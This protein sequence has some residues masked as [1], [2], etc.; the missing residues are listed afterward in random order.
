MANRVFNENQNYRGT[1]VMYL[2]LMTEVPILILLTV[3][4]INSDKDVTENLVGLTIASIAIIG[5]FLLIMNIQLQTRIDDQGIHYKFFPF[6][7]K[8]RNIPR[9]KIK[10]I[11]VIHYSPITDYGGWG[12]KGNKTTK[13]YSIVGDEGLLIDTGDSKKIMLGT[14]KGPELRVFIID[15]RED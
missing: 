5:T 14:Q 4:L 9:E 1:W 2:L 6:I 3:V 15:W 7:N 13:A 11:D 12:L 10:S 8:W